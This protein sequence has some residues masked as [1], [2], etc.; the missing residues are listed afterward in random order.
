MGE[1]LRNINWVIIKRV[2]TFVWGFGFLLLAILIVQI[3]IR[4]F[5]LL[6]IL[7]GLVGILFLYQFIFHNKY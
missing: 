5:Q 2:P 3:P 7:P 4:F 1:W 6:A